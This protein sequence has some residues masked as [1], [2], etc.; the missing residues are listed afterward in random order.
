MFA[1]ACSR[2][3]EQLP[4]FSLASLSAVQQKRRHP[5]IK[6]ALGP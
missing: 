2:H 4:L 3:G 1:Y 6:H 5:T